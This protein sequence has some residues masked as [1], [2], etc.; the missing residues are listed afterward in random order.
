MSAK[1]SN[2]S[3]RVECAVRKGLGLLGP[4][5]RFPIGPTGCCWRRL[6]HRAGPTAHHRLADEFHRGTSLLVVA[7]VSTFA[8]ASSALTGHLDFSIAWPFA[9]GALL[10][11]LAGRAIAP[12]IAGPKLQQG[13]AFLAALVAVGLIVKALLTVHT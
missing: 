7:L 3:L 6:R 9:G 10:G 1:S 13:F 8:V 4:R 2:G 5:D 12:K 11:M